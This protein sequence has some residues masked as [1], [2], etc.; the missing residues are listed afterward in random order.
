MIEKVKVAR[1]PDDA[2]PSAT[3]RGYGVV[4]RR[5]RLM[6][7]REEPICRA[8]HVADATEMD[9][10]DGNNRNLRRDNLQ[11]LCKRCHSRKSVAEQGSLKGKIPC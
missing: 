5:L 1:F 4:H 2:R 10:K 6:V 11:G 3:K 8:C 9:H 7:L